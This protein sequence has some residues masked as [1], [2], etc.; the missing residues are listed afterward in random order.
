VGVGGRVAEARARFLEGVAIGDEPP[1][2]KPLI[3]EVVSV[4][5]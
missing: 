5:R 2:K 1:P 3:I 4:D